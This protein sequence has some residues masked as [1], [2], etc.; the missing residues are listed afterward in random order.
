MYHPLGQSNQATGGT[1]SYECEN[2]GV[3]HVDFEANGSYSGGTRGSCTSEEFGWSGDCSGTPRFCKDCKLP[4]SGRWGTNFR[5]ISS[6]IPDIPE[7]FDPCANDSCKTDP[8]CHCSV[9][10]GQCSVTCE[11]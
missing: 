2:N 8:F 10:Q 7:Q 1:C 3:C 11:K 9:F 5:E 6:G 4:C